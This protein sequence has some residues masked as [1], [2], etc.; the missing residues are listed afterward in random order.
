MTLNPSRVIPLIIAFEYSAPIVLALAAY[1]RPSIANRVVSLLG[2]IAPIL[3]ILLVALVS[4]VG[5]LGSSS[6]DLG[7][8]CLIAFPYYI[9]ALCVGL[10]FAKSDRPVFFRPRFFVAM[11]ATPIAWIVVVSIVK[12]SSRISS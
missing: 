2:S 5:G 10:V 12:V 11:L 1:I 3:A 6:H 7:L 9:V 8:I 4:S